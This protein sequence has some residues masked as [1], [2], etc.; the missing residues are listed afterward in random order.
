MGGIALLDAS[1]DLIE[2][3]ARKSRQ[4][5]A[6]LAAP[7]GQAYSREHLAGLLWAD[8][9]E[10]QARSSLRTALSGIRGALG[11]NALLIQQDQV[12]LRHGCLNTDIS[13]LK[14]LSDRPDDAGELPGF[15]RGEFLS[16]YDHDSEL[17]TGWLRIMRRDSAAMALDILDKCTDRAV[18]AGD[19]VKAIALMRDSFSLEPLR[20]QIH[21]KIMRLYVANGERALAL[22]QY[23]TCKEVLLHELGVAPA[24]ETQALAKDIALRDASVSAQLRDQALPASLKSGAPQAPDQLTSLAVLPFVNMS[25]DAG[26]KFFADGI[27]EDITVDLADIETLA[28]AAKGSCEMYR[29]AAVSPAQIAD[30]LGVRFLLQGSVRTSG[31]NVRISVTLT[32]AQSNRQVWAQRYDRTLDNILELQSEISR[33]IVR[34]LKI[35]L[36]L[37]GNSP[38][39]AQ[40]T[41][42]GQAYQYY[43]HGKSLRRRNTPENIELAQQMFGRAVDLD[44]GYALAF[45]A[46]ARCISALAKLQ[47]LRGKKLKATLATAT[48]NC[49]RAQEIQPN[50]AEAFVARAHILQCAGDDDAAEETYFQAIRQNPALVDA[51]NLLAIFYMM[52]RG[53]FAKAY[54]HSKLAYDLDPDQACAAMLLTCLSDL[55]KS[56]ETDATAALVL[57]RSKR[58][59]SLDPYDFDAVHLIAYSSFLTGDR[60]TAKHWTTI[61]S[62]F[63]VDDSTFIYNIACLHS[64]LGSVDE[65]LEM[66]ERALELRDQSPGFRYIKSVDPDLAQLRKDPRFHKLLARYQ[67]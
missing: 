57:K 7:V 52:V 18:A 46:L 39:I 38:A 1:G 48:E 23:R 19:N 36:K 11:E 26:Q 21:R 63:D 55:G 37:S 50:L 56:A 35:N 49:D 32:D 16:G 6:Y 42:S 17:F 66:L 12:S 59:V 34:A 8:R 51:Q 43:L 41:S 14:S 28:V 67:A 5:L 62:A 27:T 2:L 22:A 25:G 33:A 58:R 4:L 44:P 31:D 9:Q 29:G 61:A 47:N 53:D 45:A 30:E 24:P 20:E 65:A 64:L 15:Y 54:T 10:E 13:R 60:E 40:T 3:K